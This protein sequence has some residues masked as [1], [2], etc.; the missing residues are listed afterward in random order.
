MT[1]IRPEKA[2][3]HISQKGAPAQ[4]PRLRKKLREQV[5]EA[6]EAIR[7]ARA[8]R[9]AA[10]QADPENQ[11]TDEIAASSGLNRSDAELGLF[12]V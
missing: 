1:A 11:V 3:N 4:D 12:V 7:Q 10:E 5:S 8:E 6:D 2:E 9:G